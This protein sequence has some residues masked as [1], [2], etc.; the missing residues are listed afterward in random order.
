MIYCLCL[1]YPIAWSRIWYAIKTVYVQTLDQCNK[2][3]NIRVNMNCGVALQLYQKTPHPPMTLTSRNVN[4]WLLFALWYFYTADSKLY[5]FLWYVSVC[6]L[7]VMPFKIAWNMRLKILTGACVLNCCYYS[8][9]HTILNKCFIVVYVLN[10]PCN[11]E[12]F[13]SNCNS[14]LRIWEY[15]IYYH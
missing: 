3:S 5:M 6:A 11:F 2:Y 4:Y 1:C 14:V 8:D 10:S 9:T 7:T 13:I 15:S 12:M